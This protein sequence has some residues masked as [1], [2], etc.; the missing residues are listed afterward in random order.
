VEAVSATP[1]SSRARDRGL[2]GALVSIA[3][4]GDLSLA[5]EEAAEDFDPS[6]P[7]VVFAVEELRRRAESVADSPTAGDLEQQVTALL[8]E[9]ENLTSD[10]LRYGWRPFDP[11]KAPPSA[12]LL[13]SAEGGQWG[14]WDTPGSLREVEENSRVYVLGL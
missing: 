7:T 10:P 8:S 6:D 12:V 4:L 14:E 11:L 5:A 3:R 13:R 9:W 2:H 1:F